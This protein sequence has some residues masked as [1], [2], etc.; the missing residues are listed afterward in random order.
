MRPTMGTST[1]ADLLEL[2]S[3]RDL[4]AAATW[5]SQQHLL[6]TRGMSRDQAECLFSAAAISKRLYSEGAA[7]LTDL[8]DHIVAN[9]FYENS[10]RT[11]SSFDLA[12]RKL[13]AA[14]LNLEIGASSVVKGETITDTAQTL[15]SMGVSA[16]VQRHS[17]SGSAH[18]LAEALGNRVHVINAGD[19]WNAH[20][21]QALLDVFS[22]RECRSDLGGAKVAIIG[23]ITH[24]RVARS[25]IWLLKLFGVDIHVAGPPTLMPAELDNL[26]VTVHNRLEPAI[27]GADFII[28]LRL[29]LERQQ[30]GLVPSVGEYKK[31]YRMDHH[32][33]KLASTGARVMHPGPVNRGI[34]ITDELASDRERSLIDIQVTNGIAVRMAALYLLLSPAGGHH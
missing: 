20:P 33:L 22:M 25:D 7:P 14:V 31:L 3:L 10:T 32:R 27:E 18:Q 11:R 28:T 19:G 21:T 9:L 26:G 12:A 15:V 24:S 6:D 23:D 1:A 29:Q 30:Q 5:R 2:R 13:G 8:A 4:P 16:V 34:E 17:S